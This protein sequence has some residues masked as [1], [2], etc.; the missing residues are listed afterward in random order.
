[1][2]V[3]PFLSR[4]PDTTDAYLAEAISE[5]IGS[6]LSR[7]GGLR[8]LSAS[9]VSSQWRRTPDPVDAAR[10]LKVAWYVTG[11]LR[12]STEELYAHVEVV[13]TA[14]AEQA[15]SSPFR[16][17]DDDLLA[18]EGAVAESVVVAITGRLVRPAVTASTAGPRD[19]EAHRLFLMANA[20]LTQRTAEAVIRAAKL[21]EE[22]VGRDSGHAAAW[23]GL[24]YSRVV[25]A[26]WG[27]WATD[28]PRDSLPAR[29]RIAAGR[30]LALDSLLPNAWQLRGAIGAWIDNDFN[31][32]Q[33]DFARALSL[34]SLNPEVYQGLGVMYGADRLNL[35]DSAI[36]YLRQALALNPNLPNAWRH[37]G[38]VIARTGDLAGAEA[39]LDTTVGLGPW[40]PAH[41]E[42]AWVRY[43]RGNGRGALEDLALSDR[44]AEFSDTVRHA[45]FQTLLGDSAE[46]RRL[47][48]TL[49][50]DAQHRLTATGL[51]R[52]TLD[53]A[54]GLHEAAM[55]GI[56]DM[57]A[58]LYTWASLHDPIYDPLRKDPEFQR[59]LR[60]SKAAVRWD[61]RP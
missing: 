28:M 45:I 60:A 51:A 46:A 24:G 31:R 55:A 12:R 4:S 59:V 18:L 6:R 23:A 32:A 35:P 13:R 1:V 56:R 15:W 7:V 22:A 50:A 20:L 8:V 29:A 52:V 33:A 57:P 53:I 39:V 21:Y 16:R 3:L 48:R 61:W 54:L 36:K 19:K 49:P 41:V 30:A 58:G 38:R 42:R 43:L 11:T 5:Q 9:A 34:D 14:S 44:L 2:A 27:T 10:A 37:L 40:A 25:Q 17:Q 47:V 26:S